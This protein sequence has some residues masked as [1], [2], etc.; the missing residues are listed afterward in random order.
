[1][2]TRAIISI[3]LVAVANAQY[4]LLFSGTEFFK[5]Q[6]WT[7]QYFLVLVHVSAV[8]VLVLVL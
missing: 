6:N 2:E 4:F 1:M 7:I 5:A 8:P 3:S